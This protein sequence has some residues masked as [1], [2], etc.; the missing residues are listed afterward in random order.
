MHNSNFN[1]VFNNNSINKDDTNE[2]ELLISNIYHINIIE[3]VG[4]HSYSFFE[5]INVLNKL[6]VVDI[7]ILRIGSNF[8][9]G[10]SEEYLSGKFYDVL[11]GFG[12]GLYGIDSKLNINSINCKNENS[13]LK[14]GKNKLKKGDI[15]RFEMKLI[16]LNNS[17][18]H[19]EDKQITNE[20]INTLNHKH[21]LSL[22]IRCFV[23][24]I[25]YNEEFIP[26]N[27]DL[28][29]QTQLTT[30]NEYEYIIFDNINLFFCISSCELGCNS[31]I[32]TLKFTS[33][34]KYKL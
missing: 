9:I 30:F 34:F 1:E 27:Y 24:K 33:N 8:S 2:N 21:F 6:Y 17:N 3:L 23:N 10:I 7:E 19:I 4:L 11:V 16:S 18:N 15:L 25:L 28:K 14:K 13:L 32:T 26:L 29:L 5:N 31:G 20:N 12:F 22:N